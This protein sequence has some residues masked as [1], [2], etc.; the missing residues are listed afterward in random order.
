MFKVIGFDMQVLAYVQ[1][2]GWYQAYVKYT[3]TGHLMD[4]VK[5]VEELLTDIE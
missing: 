1:A 2:E 4:D 3:V 5:H